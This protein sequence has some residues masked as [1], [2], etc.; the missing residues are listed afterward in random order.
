M[1]E[2]EWNAE[3]EI[4]NL[5]DCRLQDVTG[6]VDS[7]SLE[8]STTCSIQAKGGEDTIYPQIWDHT[9]NSFQN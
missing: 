9:M 6:G 2:K 4:V 7:I 8:I 3:L 1:N 5:D